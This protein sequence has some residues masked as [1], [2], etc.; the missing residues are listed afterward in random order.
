MPHPEERP[1]EDRLVRLEETVAELRAELAR[2]AEAG[3]PLADEPEERGVWAAR[4]A[5]LRARYD[6][7]HESQN[8]LNKVGIGLVLFGIGFLFKYSI[9]QGWLTPWVRVG[10]GLALASVLLGF[11]LAL[12]ERQRRFSQVLIGGGVSTLYLTAFAAFQ[13]YGL[14]G[15]TLAFGFLAAVALSAFLLAVRQDDTVLSLVATV[16]AFGTPFLLHSPGGTVAGLVG[17]ASILLLG[18]GALYLSRGWRSVLWVAS[19]GGWS[20]LGLAYTLWRRAPADPG[21][22]LQ[23]GILLAWA[24][25]WALPLLREALHGPAAAPGRERRRRF[26]WRPAEVA[27]LHVHLLSVTTPVTALALMRNL[28]SWPWETWGYAMVAVAAVHA[29][30]AWSL[31]RRGS[32][33]GVTQASAAAVLLSLGTVGALS[34]DR[35]YLALAAQA[36]LIHLVARPLPGRA[37]TAQGHLLFAGLGAWFA[38]RLMGEDVAGTAMLNGA[39]L[40]DLAVAALALAATLLLPARS[41]RLAYRFALHA[42]LLGWWWRELGALPSGQGYVTIVWGLYALFLLAL[43]LRHDLRLLQ[44]AA[45]GTL[46]LPVAKLFLIDLHALAVPWRIL[47]FLGFGSG[48]L[49]LSYYLQVR[50]RAADPPG[51]PRGELRARTEN[52]LR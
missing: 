47:L 1:M 37:L 35:L 49:L 40:A 50:W 36:L 30:I 6:F 2:L 39:A 19:V 18:T 34:G 11:G 3:P 33:L 20:V 13:L 16:G 38:L 45:L 21:W 7:R 28:W 23:A 41:D 25:F 24:V 5:G 14:V 31:A 22:V 44:T 29:A 48:F 42:A 26:R 15:Y 12:Y 46:L 52:R 27:R 4:L 8:W 10:I 43:G 17:Y 51:P 9:E 32:L